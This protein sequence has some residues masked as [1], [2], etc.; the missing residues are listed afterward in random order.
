[1]S[2]IWKDVIGYEGRYIVSN[3]GQVKSLSRKI[4]NGKSSCMQLKERLLK[5]SVN[6]VGYFIVGLCANNKQKTKAVHQLVAES[7]LNHASSG[8]KFEVDHI[9][10]IKTDNRLENIQI[11]TRRENSSKDKKGGTSEFIGVSWSRNHKKWRASIYINGD[12]EHLGFFDRESDA[13]KA[14]NNI[15]K[16]VK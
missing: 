10:N 13:A 5:P 8:H 6:G 9:N 11:I 12:H 7:F 2:E 1:M 16:I 3:K 4:K 14:Y 15:L